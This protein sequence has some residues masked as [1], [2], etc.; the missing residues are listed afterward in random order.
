MAEEL[1]FFT[2]EETASPHMTKGM[3]TTCPNCGLYRNCNTPKM[4]P[5]GNFK[6]GILNIGSF[7]G[8]REDK[9]GKPWQGQT[10][11][12]LKRAYKSFGIDLFEDCLNI[13]ACSCR[14]PDDRKPEPAEI[15][16]CRPRV[17][18]VI[19]RTKPHLIILLGNS[20]VQSVIGN[21]WK[22]N[23]DGIDRWRGWNIPDQDFQAWV[24]PTFHPERIETS[25]KYPEVETVWMQDL[26]KAFSF[27]EEP[28][29]RRTLEEY[30]S[31]VE[32]IEDQR[33][34]ADVLSILGTIGGTSELI[35][36]DIES[37]GLKPHREGHE[38]ACV[39]LCR[40][41]DKSYVFPWPQREK[42]L[43]Q[44]ARLLRNP[45]LYWGGH[46]IKFE[47][48]WFQHFL[49]V[50]SR[51]INWAIDTMYG[52]HYDDN[53][54]KASSLKFRTYIHFGI[55]DYDSEISSWLESDSKDANSLNRVMELMRERPELLMGYC[56]LDSLF[57]RL[58]ANVQMPLIMPF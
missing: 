20:A 38:I 19:Q 12:I 47:S 40:Y 54:P 52:A 17:L 6:K 9:N 8:P 15:N 32:I 39:S 33:G 46:N 44:F 2:K 25:A 45:S 57:T 28:F 35:V 41:P 22:K 23:L 58:L 43:I 53:R 31:C 50:S 37:T 3:R 30:K 56:G 42:R 7:P 1:G 14:T 24:C 36:T 34:I 27:I 18:D 16:C 21:R 5:Y 4:A 49:G 10:G 48:A 11:Q 55:A 13:N 29:P 26:E 51:E